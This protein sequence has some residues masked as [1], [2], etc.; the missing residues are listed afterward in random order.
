MVEDALHTYTIPIAWDIFINMS[1]DDDIETLIED[2]SPSSS[3]EEEKE[4]IEEEV[5]EETPHI[6][7]EEEQEIE[8]E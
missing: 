6:Q 5:D 8:E 1:R 4:E 7:T 3:E 2:I